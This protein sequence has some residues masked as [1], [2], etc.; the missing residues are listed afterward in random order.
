[1]GLF[2]RKLY[3]WQLDILSDE[4]KDLFLVATTVTVLLMFCCSRVRLI[5]ALAP[6]LYDRHQWLRCGICATTTIP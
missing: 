2:T 3:I 5:I 6:A 1:M 4:S